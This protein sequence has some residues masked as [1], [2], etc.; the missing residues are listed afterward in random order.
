MEAHNLHAGQG[1]V[2]LDIGGDVGAVLVS[3]PAE[4]AGSEV[5]ARPVA[6]RPGR[7]HLPHVAVLPRPVA[8]GVRY[9]AVFGELP[10]GEYQLYLR[11]DGP[12]ALTVSVRG[13]EVTEADWPL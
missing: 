12:V 9:S 2:L 8:G 3:M 1:S 10:Q 7:P 6:V 4:L 11:P 13:G 5:E